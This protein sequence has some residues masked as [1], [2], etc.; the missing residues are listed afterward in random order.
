M[1]KTNL[2]TLGNHTQEYAELSDLE[3]EAIAGG[4]GNSSK[5][6][7]SVGTYRPSAEDQGVSPTNVAGGW[8]WR[9]RR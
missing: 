2:S 5:K 9:R 3:L 8:L 4:K 7:S 6:E 1:I